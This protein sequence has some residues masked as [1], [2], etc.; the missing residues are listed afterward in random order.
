MPDRVL[1]RS[2]EFPFQEK[3][4]AFWRELLAE[5]QKLRFDRTKTRYKQLPAYVAAGPKIAEMYSRSSL[6][7]G[8][9]RYQYSSRGTIVDVLLGIIQEGGLVPH[10]DDW[11]LK[12]ATAKVTC[13]AMSRM[14]ARLYAGMH[15]PQGLRIENELGSR[16]LWAYYFFVTSSIMAIR[17]FRL[18]LS[19][20]MKR[21]LTALVP[22]FAEKNRRWVRKISSREISQKDAFLVG[23]DIASNYPILIGIKDLAFTPAQTSRYIGLHERRAPTPI[24]LADV[25]HIE[26]PLDHTEETLRL[27]RKFGVD[28]IN[29]IPLEFGE[30]FSRAF[31]FWRLVSGKRLER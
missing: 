8:T 16:E 11:D 31:S 6:W 29:V 24:K 1:S 23:T 27:L 28:W 7:H 4:L 9:G 18:S 2:D 5:I 15:S 21:D 12:H 14:Y 3:G 13:T 30:E 10:E 19:A 20:V 17:E 26:V 22:D 25:S